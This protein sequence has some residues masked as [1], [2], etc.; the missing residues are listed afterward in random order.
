M[1]AVIIILMSLISF[2]GISQT[3]YEKGMQ[4]ALDLWEAKKPIEAVNL[5]E[6][7]AKAEPEQWLPSYYVSYLL[8]ITSFNEE[9]ETKLKAQMDKAL[10]YMNDAK[11]I[12]KDETEL[13]LLEALWY[14]VWVAKDGAVYGMKYGGKISGIYQEAIVKAPNN[15]RVI[16]NKTE[17][18]I[19]GAKFFGKPIEPY[20][21]EIKKAIDL[22]ENYKPEG[23][24]YPK[25][26]LQRAKDLL[27]ENCSN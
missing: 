19:G 9:D 14:T 16:L 11:T 15:P 17:W 22:F 20:C 4:K 10:N 26:G 27:K 6:R 2:S 25:G 24:F 18:D 13:S 3:P 8:V 12:S 21:V 23:N 5:F 1:K 7:I